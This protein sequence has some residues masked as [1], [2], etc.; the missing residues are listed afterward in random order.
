MDAGRTS[1]PAVL[2]SN[3]SGGTNAPLA[4]L[5]YAGVL[6]TSY[7]RFESGVEYQTIVLGP[8]W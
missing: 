4:E 5:A 7:S 8:Y 3:P 2:G 6:E 1:N